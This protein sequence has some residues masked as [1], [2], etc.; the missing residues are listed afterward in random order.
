[1][2]YA[3]I[4][5]VAACVP[6]SATGE[7]QASGGTLGTWTFI[8]SSCRSGAAREFDGVDLFDGVRAVRLVV[9]PSKGPTLVVALGGDPAMPSAIFPASVC[10]RF[11]QNVVV[12]GDGDESVTGSFDVTCTDLA[13]S[14]RFTSCDKDP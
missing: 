5:L 8:P 14:I 4:V 10:T 13:G 2:R 6:S 11:D 7:L 3:I 9:D 12:D 1:M